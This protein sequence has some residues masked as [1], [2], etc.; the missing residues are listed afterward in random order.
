M[1]LCVKAP[2]TLVSFIAFDPALNSNELK[3]LESLDYNSLTGAEVWDYVNPTIH[4]GEDDQL[5]NFVL[6]CQIPAKESNKNVEGVFYMG[7]IDWRKIFKLQFC[8]WKWIFFS[9]TVDRIKDRT[10]KNISTVVIIPFHPD[11]TQFLKNEFERFNDKNA[12]KVKKDR[13]IL[14]FTKNGFINGRSTSFLAIQNGI[15]TFKNT[16]ID[17][18]TTAFIAYTNF[19]GKEILLTPWERIQMN[20]EKKSPHFQ[21][22]HL[23][24]YSQDPK[25]DW[26]LFNCKFND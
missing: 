16:L 12:K 4:P 9:A 19:D 6:E 1:C 3:D 23:R 8:E 2:N 11:N 22:L 26:G 15:E 17:G 5:F 25:V 21:S 14:R 13:S 20:G 18:L 24:D 7:K 10:I